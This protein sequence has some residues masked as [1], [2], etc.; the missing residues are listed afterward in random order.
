M[1]FVTQVLWKWK[2]VCTFSS[3]GVANVFCASIV[4]G[5]VEVEHATLWFWCKVATVD[6]EIAIR[7]RAHSS[8]LTTLDVRMTAIGNV[9]DLRLSVDTTCLVAHVSASHIGKVEVCKH[10]TGDHIASVGCARVTIVAYNRNVNLNGLVTRGNTPIVCACIAIV[11][12]ERFKYTSSCQ[13]VATIKCAWIRIITHLI[14]ILAFA[15]FVVANVSSA[16]VSIAA[17]HH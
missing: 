10:A 9:T 16:L 6:V 14:M 8:V 3:F 13:S 5:T 15:C 17:E 2:Q 11:Y 4:I 7:L 12:V 1:D